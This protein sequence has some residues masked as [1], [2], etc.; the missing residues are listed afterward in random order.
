MTPHRDRRGGTFRIDRRFPHVGR[1]ARAS[2]TT[3][4]RTFRAIDATL[5]A[6]YAAGRLDVLRGIQSGLLKPLQV[7]EAFRAN[8]LEALPSAEMMAPLA[9]AVA[10]WLDAVKH[11]GTRAS[12][13]SALARLKAPDGA[14]MGDLPALLSTFRAAADAAD[15]RRAFNLTKAAAQSFVRATL[16]KAH[17]MYAALRGVE[18]LPRRTKVQRRPLSVPEL[19]AL[20]AALAAAPS[21]HGP[22]VEGLPAE[23]ARVAMVMATSGMHAEELWGRWEV[24]TDR[25]RVHGTKREA[26]DRDV[27]RVLDVTWWRALDPRLTPKGF[28]GR[29]DR[30]CAAGLPFRVTPYDLRRTFAN[31]MED[32]GVKR[33]MRRL[34][35]GHEARDVTDLY[36]WRALLTAQLSEDAER[37]RRYIDDQ[38][39]PPPGLKI[40]REGDA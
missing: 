31:L 35:M 16:G 20:C 21:R 5:D 15:H 9:P 19:D 6:L 30:A 24:G 14:K 36:E 23:A 12:Y 11:P 39:Q 8:R 37:I 27:P 29:L 3:D 22:T 34:Y 4:P 33:T 18:S 32:A 28:A 1:I 25:V 13:K 38:R 2:G 26:R 17:A 7:L 10:A 40:V